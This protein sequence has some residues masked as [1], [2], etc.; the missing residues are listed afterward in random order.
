MLTEFQQGVYNVAAMTTFADW[1]IA[2][3]QQSGFTQTMLAVE[4]AERL[5]HRKIGRDVIWKLEH[6]S[7]EYPSAEVVQAIAAALDRPVT[8]A[9]EALGYVLPETPNAKVHPAL[10]AFARSLPWSAQEQ[11]PVLLPML[12]ALATKIVTGNDTFTP[13]STV[14]NDTTP[15]KVNNT[16]PDIERPIV[17]PSKVANV[18]RT[19]R[20]KSPR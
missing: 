2:A 10:V 16:A 9:L 20:R 7:P 1:I 19:L 11:L 18:G 14:A 12:A 4:L 3:R 15:A 8:E 5:P 17:P 13:I 6:G